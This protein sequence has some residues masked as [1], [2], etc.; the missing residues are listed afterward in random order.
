MKIASLSVVTACFCAVSSA[1][2]QQP[3]GLVPVQ[4]RP[5]ATSPPNAQGPG[6]RPPQTPVLRRRHPA[7]AAPFRLSAAEQAEVDRVLEAWEQQS[8]RFRKFECDFTRFEYDEVFGQ[9]NVPRFVD[10]G[11]IK[12][13]APDKGVFRVTHTVK[14]GRVVPIEPK[15]AEHWICDGK[16]IYGYDFVQ[17]QLVEHQLPPEL[18]GKSISNGPLPFLF[19]VEADQLKRRYWIRIV[20]PPQTQGEI[21]LEAFPR[22]QADAANFQRAEMILKTTGMQPYALQ[23]HLPGG[24]QRTVYQFTNVRINA[25]DPTDLLDL[26]PDN[27]FRPK[28]PAGWQKIVQQPETPEQASRSSR[29]RR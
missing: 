5:A 22:F 21:W 28:L 26:F 23:L 6:V 3:G 4:P 10:L 25:R 2:A 17:K 1:V 8:A 27:D 19:G 16:A 15:R 24:Q 9:R 7:A 29:P 20:T 11:H 12:Y 13:A 18:Q 14:E